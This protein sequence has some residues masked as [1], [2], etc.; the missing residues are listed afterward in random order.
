M[1]HGQEQLMKQGIRESL[2]KSKG[3][4]KV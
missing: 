1:S 2:D 4:P 3:D